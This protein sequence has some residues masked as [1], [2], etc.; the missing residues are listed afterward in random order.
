MNLSTKIDGLLDRVEKPARY[1]GSE[2]HMAVKDPASVSTR[3]GFAFPDT[4][5]IGMSYLGLQILYHIMNRQEDIYCER[6]FAPV[7]D[8][9]TLMRQEGIPL[10]TMETRTPAGELDILG[11]TLQYELSYSN[12][13]NM[14][15]LAGLPLK[16]AD[17]GE[18]TPFVCAGGPCAFNPEPLAELVD[19][20]MIGDGED[21]VL[22]VCRAHRDWKASGKPKIAF[23]EAL[24][25]LPGIYVPRFYKPLYGENGAFAGM[26]RLWEGAPERVEK[27]IAADL[28]ACDFPEKPLVPLVEV[29]H[30]RAV[31]EIFRGC[32]R[33]CRFCQAGMVY[34]PVRE[35]EK[36]T[37]E[38][39]AAAQLA[40]SGHEEISLLSLSTSDHSQVE[41]LV[42]E[43]MKLCKKNNV[44]LSLPSLRLDS[45]SF[46]VLEEIQGYKKTGLT[47]AP[48]AGT[49]RLRNV[50]N[51]NITAENIYG[52][53]EQAVSL[54][55]NSVKLYFM[56]GLPTETFA[57]LD[58]IAE[59]AREIMEISYRVNGSRKGGRFHIG[60]SVSNFVPKPH[61][62][63]QWAAQDRPEVFDKKHRHLR[64]KLRAIK[65]VTFRYH[66]T[67]TSRMEAIFAKGDRRLGDVLIRAR[68]LGCKFDGWSEHYKHGLWQQAFADCGVDGD[69]YAYRETSPEDPL[70]WDI[71]DSGVSKE[72]LA[73]EWRKALREETTEDCRAGCA[74]C[75]INRLAE[76]PVCGG[77]EG[78]RA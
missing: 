35:R 29:V 34:R 74:G 66:G 16:S 67:E 64:E 26:E 28:N 65:G 27:R 25:R 63:F 38:R 60:V 31:V 42:R 1:I 68:E 45:F 21:A 46:N 11:F 4:Y 7:G 33:G 3:F 70:P 2:L 47:F 40:A 13:V 37:I 69:F 39:L 24:A 12:V 20:F 75:G 51:K 9:E 55:W 56:A 18:G 78:G 73:E 41:P 15:D 17:R 54:G 53:M 23:L 5:E 22:D 61:T 32:S 6:L 14:M 62:P 8:M 49:Q 50:I 10:F 30:D 72:F 76:C 57:D 48:E 71:I 36:D 59:T 44:S 19:F 77:G 58:G 43:L 52:A